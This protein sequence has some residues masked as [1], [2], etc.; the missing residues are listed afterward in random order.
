[1]YL[2]DNKRIFGFELII[3]FFTIFAQW[4]IEERKLKSKI[5]S[6]MENL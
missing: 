6:E 4:K 2:N 1:M 3:S 5:N